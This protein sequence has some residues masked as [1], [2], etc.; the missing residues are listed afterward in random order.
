V[1]ET[2]W[3]DSSDHVGEM[4]DAIADLDIV[5]RDGAARGGN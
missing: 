1:D 3:W 4:L 2:A 5:T